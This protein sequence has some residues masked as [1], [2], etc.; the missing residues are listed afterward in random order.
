MPATPNNYFP[1]YNGIAN[2]SDTLVQPWFIP[3]WDAQNIQQD[4][5]VAIINGQIVGPGFPPNAVFY[6]VVGNYFDSNGSGLSGFITM[7]MSDGIT[8]T[9]SGNTYRLPSRYVGA[10]DLSIPFA[11]NNW[12]SQRLFIRYGRLNISLMAT[13]QAS[14]GGTIICDN[15]GTLFYWVTEHWLGGRV[16]QI[17]LPSTATSPVDINSLI[18]PGTIVPYQY[19]PVNP[20]G[21]DLTRYSEEILDTDIDGGQSGSP[22]SLNAIDGGTG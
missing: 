22:L 7:K 15:G 12:G 4:T 13:D 17:T 19:D 8:M 18:V 5:K 6:N 1:T 14:I 21:N 2:A 10:M 20:G 11:Y 3:G 9:V 16:F